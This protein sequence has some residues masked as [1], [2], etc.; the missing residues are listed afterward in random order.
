VTEPLR[1]TADRVPA[2]VALR[3]EGSTYVAAPQIMARHTSHVFDCTGAFDLLFDNITVVGDGN[4]RPQTAWFLARDRSGG[5]A[6]RHR[7]LN[8][9][10]RGY[11]SAA[12]VYSYGSEE[13]VYMAP[14]FHN[15]AE[16]A[17][18]ITVTGSNIG[19]LEAPNV[20]TGRQSNLI[21]AMYGGSLQG[22]PGPTGDVWYLDEAAG[23][24][25]Y[26]TWMAAGL[27]SGDPAISRSGRSLCYVDATNGAS[28]DCAFRDSWGERAVRGAVAIHQQYGFY[29]GNERS[30]THVKFIISGARIHTAPAEHTATAR[31]SAGST[32]LQTIG[33]SDTDVGA[34]VTG[35]GIPAGTTVRS[36]AGDMLVMSAAAT[37][38][39]STQVTI[40]GRVVF[41]A[42]N[43][44][45][46]N[47][48]IEHVLEGSPS[49][50]IEIAG[51]AQ[52]SDIR[53]LNGYLR[54][55]V[56]RRNALVGNSGNWVVGTR[57]ADTWVDVAG[58]GAANAGEWKPVLRATSGTLSY[59][60]QAGSFTRLAD[61]VQFSMQISVDRLNG[62]RGEIVI[63]GLPVAAARGSESFAVTLNHEGL[64]IGS[65]S[66]AAF[67]EAGEAV[68][69]VRLIR[70]GTPTHAESLGDGNLAAGCTLRAT[71]TYRV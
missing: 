46:D 15:L 18:V 41:A 4:T 1:L 70:P 54:I 37:A 17:K 35:A 30:V 10:A 25:V 29:F 52:H 6:G 23:V 49:R 12:V 68:I 20:A 67:I 7:F 45:L 66:I 2:G 22:P 36:R 58:S 62:A 51:T 69:R 14:V 11:F 24:S 34:V 39:G 38:S 13:N 21:L 27:G 65:A 53:T 63:G 59:S 60:R 33:A 55:N 43:V 16:D 28:N 42:P 71:G 32:G 44:T 19:K 64:N 47:C 8:C 31:M 56:S 61:R 40:G 5:S 26:A 48:V 50:G 9:R 3:G 57:E